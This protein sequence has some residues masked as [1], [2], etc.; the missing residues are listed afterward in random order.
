[1][2]IIYYGKEE[3][4]L[5]MS[6]GNSFIVSDSQKRIW[7]II[8]I[9]TSF[10]KKGGTL[11]MP[12]QALCGHKLKRFH[13]TCIFCRARRVWQNKM[14]QMI[15]VALYVLAIQTSRKGAK[16]KGK[17]LKVLLTLS[18]WLSN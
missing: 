16:W 15:P 18:E 5:I 12:C 17:L 8:N 6:L 3:Y 7:Q 9:P 10:L 1:M 4:K 13:L 2:T 14:P 11:S